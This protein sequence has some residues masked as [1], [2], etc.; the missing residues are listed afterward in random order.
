MKLVIFHDYL[1]QKG[2]GEKLVLEL[3][4]ELNADI[5]TSRLDEKIVREMGFETSNIIELP[6]IK[7]F[8]PISSMLS[9]LFCD[10]SKKY[11]FFIFSGSNTL[12]A[13]KK[14]K[15]NLYYCHDI[16]RGIL[17]PLVK[18]NF[19]N[20][21]KIISNSFFTKKNLKQFSG[22]DSKVIYP[23]I[24]CSS[25]SFSKSKGYWLSVSRIYPRKRIELQS[26]AFRLLPEKKLIIVGEAIDQSSNSVYKKSLIKNKPS[27]VSFLD[28]LN[29]KELV[30]FYSECEGFIATSK[31]EPFGM[32]VAEALASG[33]AVV[34]VDEGGF[35]ETVSDGATGFLVKADANALAGAVVKVSKTPEKY[36]NACIKR[37]EEFDSGF[38]IKK[39]E[40][41]IK[42][43][44]RTF[45]RLKN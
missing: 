19:K 25:F 7:L 45:N 17:S 21:S 6:R 8:E 37:A 2:G 31:N 26:D 18:M 13:S 35:K 36:K 30:H 22:F 1:S 24:N 34:C 39:I 3:A 14:H 27:N 10:F 16:P 5:I 15:P 23:P 32:S 11:N 28:G 43:I 4:R 12:F 9:F 38:F 44:T 29:K 33:K 41:E 42:P 20:I 40:A